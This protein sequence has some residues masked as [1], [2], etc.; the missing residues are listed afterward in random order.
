MTASTIL[1]SSDIVNS[2]GAALDIGVPSTDTTPTKSEIEAWVSEATA[3]LAAT[4]PANRIPGMVKSGEPAVSAGVAT[5]SD[6]I[7]ILEVYATYSSVEYPCN[8]YTEWQVARF[9]MFAPNACTAKNPGCGISYS[10]GDVTLKFIPN[11]ASAT[12]VI[13]V[14]SP[15]KTSD[16][17]TTSGPPVAWGPALVAYGVMMGKLQDEEPDIVSGARQVWLD[18]LNL[19]RGPEAQYNKDG[20]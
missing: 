9:T 13:Y 20:K 17:T 7:R 4:L 6:C 19:L 3:V 18:A 11:T 15:G 2:I 10:G 16:W 12:K 8:L 14:A 1:V 5:V